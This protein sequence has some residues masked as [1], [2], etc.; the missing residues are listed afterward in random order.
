MRRGE[1]FYKVASLQMVIYALIAVV[2]ALFDKALGFSWFLGASVAILPQY[3]FTRWVF[4]YQGAKAIARIVASL[5]Q[6]EVIKFI[7]TALLFVLVLTQIKNLNPWAFF[8]AFLM[9][10][11]SHWF[12]A[13]RSSKKK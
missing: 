6:A 5:Y 9:A 3:V 13:L 2:I 12:L 11:F 8:I 4:R 10:I 1:L 7:M